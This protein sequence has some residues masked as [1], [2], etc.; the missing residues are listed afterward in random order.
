MTEYEAIDK[1][2]YQRRMQG[3]TA[4]MEQY[5]QIKMQYPE[6]LL[7]YRMGDFYEL[8]FEDA[9]AAAEILDIALTKR[10]KSDGDD[11]S[12]C[13]VP[14]HS[15][16][17]Y[18]QKLIASGKTVVVC[19]QMETPEQ[20]KKRGYKAVV[21]RE[22]V[23]I[24]TPG[25]IFE[26]NLLDAREANYLA[27][28]VEVGKKLALSWVDIST[29]KF[30]VS[31]TS[32]ETLSADLAR[33]NIKELLIADKL[34]IQQNISNVVRQYRGAVTPQ[35]A[36]MFDSN[37]CKHSAEKYYKVASLEAFGDFSRPHLA[38]IGALIEYINMTQQGSI[39]RL[40]PPKIFK[41]NQFMS[42][43]SA[44]M[45]NLEILTNLSGEKKGSVLNVI[46]KTITGCGARLLRDYFSAPLADADAINERLNRIQFF[47]DNIALC[48]DIRSQLKQ[49]PDIERALCRISMDKALPRDL[50]AVREG[51]RAAVSM[52]ELLEFGGA[53]DIPQS[54][55]V[56][57][58]GLGSYD[59]LQNLLD[60]AIIV[61][62]GGSLAR[63]GGYIKNGYHARLD[64]LR[65]LHING[66]SKIEDL[67]LRYKDRTGASSLK[68][69]RNNVLG[70]F[71]EVTP[72][73]ADNLQQ[74]DIFNHRQSLASAIRF[75]TEELR[76]LESDINNAY[77]ESIK[78]EQSI[79]QELVNIIN[80]Q[81][82]RLAQTSYSIAVLDVA[83]ALAVLAESNN[84]TRP[85]IDYSKSF[86][87]EG[88]RHP[89][90]ESVEDSFVSNNCDLSVEKRLW[91]ITGPNMSGKSTFLRQNA[92]IT[93]LAQIGCYVP[94]SKAHIGIVDKVFSRVGASDDLASGRSTFMVEMVETATILHQAS[95]RSLVIL[96]E[97]GRGTATFD[98]LSI[99]WA[100]VEFLHNKTKCRGLFATHYHELTTL[101]ES[102]PSLF[103]AT[104]KVREW[105]GEVI[106]MHEVISG[107]ADRSYGIHVAKLAGIPENVLTRAEN[108]LH[109]LEE[110]DV[111]KAKLA[112]VNDLPLFSNFGNNNK[113]S[114]SNNSKLEQQLAEINPDE[115]SPKQAWECLYKLKSLLVES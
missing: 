65:D 49:I 105:K 93:I 39:P 67:Q 46:D 82:Q 73:Y 33:L 3:A 69:K 57:Q 103:C 62:V 95:E 86:D 70:Y 38:A 63:D 111:G 101:S 9:V 31:D 44:T 89:V 16:Q 24:V 112:L 88:G 92:L 60:D 83:S 2:V 17:P 85:V 43:D 109:T 59:E 81:A 37:R 96:D 61:D 77:E 68:I 29:G 5:L 27:C 20:A 64:E 4:M 106:F 42:I 91:L 41:R 104:I 75:T 48:E 87:I 56:H 35:A 79:F 72:Q 7:F 108:I 21:R 18:L 25:T 113:D 102:L 40:N 107:K 36:S 50:V 14:H 32:E 22:V 110:S 6:A 12:M 52:R 97:I 84:Y 15:H 66:R 34:F 47:I 26:E 10:G 94:A 98:G 45:R 13:G 30:F 54:I 100:V 114:I 74:D 28:I 11:I 23:R 8:F 51:I 71:V 1:S 90:V 58:N 55:Y 19:E 76:N 115:L 80:S 53:I 99:A 78:I